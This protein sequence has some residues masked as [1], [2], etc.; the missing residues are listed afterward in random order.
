[1]YQGVFSVNGVQGVYGVM[2]H[3]LYYCTIGCSFN[4]LSMLLIIYITAPYSAH[5]TGCPF[6]CL[7]MLLIIYTTTVYTTHTTG[8]SS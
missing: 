2:L 8:C 4:C 6:Y 7:S 5:T 1:M 3:F